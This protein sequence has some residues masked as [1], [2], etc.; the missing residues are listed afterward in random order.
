MKDQ[1]KII[2]IILILILIQKG[3]GE[4]AMYEAQIIEKLYVI[5]LQRLTAILFSLQQMAGDGQKNLLKK[6]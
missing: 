1:K 4:V 2:R 5:R 6:N 3:F